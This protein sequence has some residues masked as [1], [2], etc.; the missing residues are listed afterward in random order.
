MIDE[1]AVRVVAE[2]GQCHGDVGWAVTAAEAAKAAGCWGFKVQVLDPARIAAPDAGRY[3]ATAP[4]GPTSQRDT[5]EGNGVLDGG[6]VREI[7]AECRRIGIEAFGTP[8]APDAVETLVDAGARHMKIASGDVTYRRLLDAVAATGL[9]VFLSTGASDGNE[10]QRAYGRLRDRGAGQVWPLACSLTYPCPDDQAHLLRIPYLRSLYGPRVGYSDHT[11]TVET[12]MVAA[13]LGAVVLERHFTVDPDGGSPDDEMA[14]TP[15]MMA[16]YVRGAEAG[17]RMAGE[18]GMHP[19][20]A[21]LPARVGA[22]RSVRWARD[23]PAGHVVGPEDIVE[24]RPCV[25]RGISVWFADHVIGGTVVDPVQAG[26]LV[27]VGDGWRPRQEPAHV[28]TVFSGR[29]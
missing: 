26:G 7:F 6:Q 4:D 14:L 12:G 28:E 8:F 1:S 18:H 10:V 19:V 16:A 3:W 2:A 17:R 25:D 5:F 29:R 21:E 15:L 24:Q 11:L 13:A 27:V 20:D 23:L 22:R 9:P